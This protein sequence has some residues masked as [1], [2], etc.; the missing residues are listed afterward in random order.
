MAVGGSYI[1]AHVSRESWIGVEIEVE[2]SMQSYLA[3]LDEELSD[4]PG[5]KKPPTRIARKRRTISQTDPDSGYINHSNKR[6]I[7]YLMEATVD[8]R[9]GI[10]R[11]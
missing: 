8:C 4:Q 5:F 1:P 11:C 2:Q 10:N 7:G 3:S 9:H 6:G